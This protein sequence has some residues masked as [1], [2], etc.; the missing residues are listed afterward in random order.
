[1]S[2]KTKP[3]GY[4]TISAGDGAPSRPGRSVRDEKTEL[5]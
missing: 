5:L 3:H 2:W 1:M 4:D